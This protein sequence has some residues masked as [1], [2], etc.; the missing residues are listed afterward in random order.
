MNQC[1]PSIPTPTIMIAMNFKDEFN[2]IEWI[3]FHTLQGFTLL[4]VFDD[5][6]QHGD[7]KTINDMVKKMT[8][9]CHMMGTRLLYRRCRK[10][11]KL[12]YMRHAL[13]I[14]RQCHITWMIYID[15][16]EYIV[17]PPRHVSIHHFLSECPPDASGIALFWKCFGSH[18][19]VS[20]PYSGTRCLSVYLSSESSITPKLKTLVRVDHVVCALSPHHYRF[21]HGKSRLWDPMTMSWI[22]NTPNHTFRQSLDKNTPHVYPYL[23]HYINQSW[24]CFCR[25]RRRPR[26]DT[27]CCREFSY[28][29][30]PTRPP[31]SQFVT[32]Y[33]D[34]LTQST[35]RRYLFIL[36]KY[37]TCLLNQKDVP[38]RVGYIRKLSMIFQKH[39]TVLSLSCPEE[40]HTQDRSQEEETHHT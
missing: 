16:D 17:L 10:T 31:P 21:S 40:T 37:I 28:S 4:V 32:M 36:F 34:T 33:N 8:S 23:S 30:D 7:M 35:R 6:S 39:L 9:F 38:E 24:V 26:D 27:G 11:P 13:D 29:L 18:H 2:I 22:E 12:G 19:L 15:A 20:S 1:P 3:L 14:A 5:D 25:R